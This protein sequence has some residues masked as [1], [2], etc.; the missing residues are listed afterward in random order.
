MWKI[1]TSIEFAIE[2]K[3][4]Q[5]FAFDRIAHLSK[6]L[7]NVSFKYQVTPVNASKK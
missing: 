7:T 4:I 2:S 1:A 6:T 3:S 5:K